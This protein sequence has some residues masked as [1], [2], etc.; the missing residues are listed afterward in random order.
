MRIGQRMARFISK[1]NAFPAMVGYLDWQNEK[2]GRPTP[3]VKAQMSTSVLA[4]DFALWKAR[5]PE[6]GENFWD[7]LGD[8]VVQVGI[9]NVVR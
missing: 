3:L 9:S 8:L 7:S 2:S 5:R 6:D 1:V 4:A